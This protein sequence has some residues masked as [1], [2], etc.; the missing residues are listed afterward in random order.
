MKLGIIGHGNI[1]REL[2]RL[3]AAEELFS[4]V[5]ATALVR[6][7]RAAAIAHVHSVEALLAT[8]PD[9]IVEAAGHDAVKTCMGPCLAAGID[10]AVASVGALADAFLRNDLEAA[11]VKGG[12][13]LIIPSG[14]IGG[15]DMLAALRTSGISS[16]VY[17]GRKPP[18]AWR[19]SPAED[20]INLDDLENV[21]TFFEGSARDAAQCY[22]KNANVAA[23][24]ALAGIGFDQTHVRLVAD[25]GA[26]G[27]SHEYSV[28]ASGTDF[29]FSVQGRASAE[30]PRTSAVTVFSLL[31]EI[32]NRIDTL[33][34]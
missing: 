4:A 18:S 1:G 13:R 29:R 31:R 20:M 12:A 30:N 24:I 8:G 17:S 26:K 22:P 9:F 14:A 11:A 6:P 7:G 23:T 34:V 33:A 5:E 27:N 15:I 2:T 10:V 19:G 25:P 3:M 28:T 21:T 32:R 16:V